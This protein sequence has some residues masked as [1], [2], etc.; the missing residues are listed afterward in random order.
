MSEKAL[1]KSEMSTVEFCQSA[2]R[3]EIAPPSAGSVKARIRLAA[4]RVGWS[5]SRTKDVWYADHRVSITGLE[6][7]TIEA[8]SGWRYAQKELR[9]NDAILAQYEAILGG[10]DPDFH[11][12]FLTALRAAVGFVGRPMGQRD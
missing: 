7:K 1:E 5:F 3:N 12:G 9:T 4:H 2:L 8:E 11:R 6:L 10:Q